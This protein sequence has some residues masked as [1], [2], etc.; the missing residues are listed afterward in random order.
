MHAANSEK[1]EAPPA[2]Q[3]YETPLPQGNSQPGAN[4]SYYN[5]AP[6]NGPGAEGAE[7][8]KGL[9]STVVGG[10]AG[11]YAGHKMGGGKLGAAAG[12]ALGAIGLNMATHA[13]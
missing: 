5:G 1:L 13:M 8:E 10:A 7:D 6:M 9:G 2:S 3:A 11:G 4:A 12:A